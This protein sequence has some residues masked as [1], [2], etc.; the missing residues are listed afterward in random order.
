[1][2]G[3]WLCHMA[4]AETGDYRLGP[5][6]VLEVAIYGEPT[7]SGPVTLDE[8]GSAALAHVGSVPLD[9]MTPEQAALRIREAYMGGWL[10]DPSV[11]VRVTTYR[12]QKV[13]VY[14]AVKKPGPYYLQGETT[15]REVLGE[16]GWVDSTKATR[17]VEVRRA[18][19][20]RVVVSIDDLMAATAVANLVLAPG[21]VVD[22]AQDV[23]VYVSGSV[24]S[25]GDVAFVEGMTA[26]VAVTE[27][28]GWTNTAALGNAYVLRG[29]ERIRVNLRSIHRGKQADLALHAGDRLV[30]RESPF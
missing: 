16:A 1:M 12:A 11:T 30:I 27:A 22:V 26:T 21:D 20:E 9:G 3:L 24:K 10:V 18:N 2:V 29:T 23:F 8:R 17:R 14:G 19:G 7:L 15:L 6:D 5:R 4:M 13:E 28:G 25:P